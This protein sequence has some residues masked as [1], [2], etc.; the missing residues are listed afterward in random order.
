MGKLIPCEDKIQTSK[1]KYNCLATSN[2]C[3]NN[4]DSLVRSH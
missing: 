2:V 4:R 3:Y 1:S